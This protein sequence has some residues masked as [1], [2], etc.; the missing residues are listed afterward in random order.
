MFLLTLKDNKE[1][2]AYAVQNRYGEK[3]LFL[4]ED[5]DDADRYAMQLKESEDADMNVVEVDDALAI[6]TCK[7][8]NYK[9]AV[10]TPN[11]IVIPP[12]DLDD[13]FPED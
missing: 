13:N 2:G 4:F 1:D 5:E 9:Y 3:V 12:R 7:R 6:L 10:V 8:Y 11:D